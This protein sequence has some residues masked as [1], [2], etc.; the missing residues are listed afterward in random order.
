MLSRF[1][2]TLFIS[3]APLILGATVQVTGV[4]FAANPGRTY[5]PL[6]EAAELLGWESKVDHKSRSA[7]LNGKKLSYWSLR[8]YTT[9][10]LLAEMSDLTAAGATV[11]REAGGASTTVSAGE[12]CFLVVPGEKKVFADL[13]AHRLRAWEGQRLVLDCHISAGRGR[14]TPAGDFKAGPYKARSHR[15]SRYNNAPMPYSVQIAGHVF[16]HGFSSVPKYHA[17]HGCIRMHLDQGNPARYF[18]EWVDRGTPVRISRTSP[19]PDE[20]MP[21]GP[22]ETTASAPAV[23]PPANTEGAEAPQPET[24]G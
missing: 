13:E 14:R 4:T 15:S 8:R 24:G 19:G 10:E 11:T 20:T 18:Y 3:L 5:L 12:K 7:E 9:G 23:T 1:F 6:T 17:S 22:K 2:F 16:V 21:F